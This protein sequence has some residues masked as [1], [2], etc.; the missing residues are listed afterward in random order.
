MLSNRVYLLGAI[1]VLVSM[2]AGL[3]GMGVRQWFEFM[4]APRLETNSLWFSPWLLGALIYFPLGVE[5]HKGGAY[6]VKYKFLSRITN[7][8]GQIFGAILFGY[9]IVHFLQISIPMLHAGF[10]R[11]P[12]EFTYIFK[13]K[14][15]GSDDYL[16]F[17]HPCDGY[18]IIAINT[19]LSYEICAPDDMAWAGRPG[20][21]VI[22][23]GVGSSYGVYYDSVELKPQNGT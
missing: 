2:T 5:M 14:A 20:D 17:N 1:F 16:R 22:L 10:V 6:D 18:N 11:K 12:V 4:P 13:D 21:K 19:P 8:F 15:F 9:S 23:K 7:F 3:I